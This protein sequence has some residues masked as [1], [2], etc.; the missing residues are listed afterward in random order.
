MIKIKIMGIGFTQHTAQ[1]VEIE[2]WRVK[3][4]CPCGTIFDLFASGKHRISTLN[5]AAA[6][7]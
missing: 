2:E 3:I 4:L 6:S 1:R 7:Y 5:S